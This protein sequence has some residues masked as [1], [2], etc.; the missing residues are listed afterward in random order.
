MCVQH[1]ENIIRLF[2]II[3]VKGKDRKLFS[4]AYL[5]FSLLFIFSFSYSDTVRQMNNYTLVLEYADGG[6]LNNYL[7][8]HFNELDWCEKLDL[9]I[10]LTSAVEFLHD[11][12]IIH[13]DLVINEFLLF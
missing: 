3:K 11:E 13:R 10:Q 7:G 4:V 12:E 2:G 9:A 8:E 1:H 5:I 6:T